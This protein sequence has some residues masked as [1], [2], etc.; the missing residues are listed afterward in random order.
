[1]TTEPRLPG[2]PRVRA[3]YGDIVRVLGEPLTNREMDLFILLAR[4]LSEEELACCWR[5]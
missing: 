5:S 1:M 4:W 3:R 2:E